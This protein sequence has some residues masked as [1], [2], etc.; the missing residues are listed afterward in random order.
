MANTPRNLM[1]ALDQVTATLRARALILPQ[2]LSNPLAARQMEKTR[3]VFDDDNVVGAGV[4]E[5][6]IEGQATGELALV[7]YVREKIAK[8]NL[9]A[10]A[11][12]PAVLAGA[13]DK[14]IFTDIVEVG[15]IVPEVNF[16]P[17]PLRSGFSISHKDGTAGTLGAFVKQQRQQ[18]VLSNSHVLAE[19]G[20][21]QVGDAILYPG[22]ADGGAVNNQMGSLASFIPFVVGAS[23][24]NTVDAAI[25]TISPEL[26]SGIEDSLLGA[27]QPLRIATPTRGMRVIK[28][29]RTTGDT[30]SVIRDTDFRIMIEYPV[31]TVGFTGQVRCDRYTEPG[32]SG[33]IVVDKDSGA[34]VGLHFAGS[35]TTSVFTPIRT[36]L[37]ALKIRF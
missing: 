28:R 15:N 37:Q 14:A 3:S 23:F 34:I 10:E 25:A 16:G 17:P 27:S 35:P 5:K 2:D 24:A 9:S 20:A 6:V 36:V 12:I 18:F 32:D 1:A 19:S 8:A 33:S 29:G 31:G 21:A 26:A 11:L 13:G 30:E 7:F 22:P 4:A